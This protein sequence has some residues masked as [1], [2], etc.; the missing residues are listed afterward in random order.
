MKNIQLN[1]IW[2]CLFLVVLFS[3]SLIAQ[4]IETEEAKEVVSSGIGAIVGGDVAHAR[5][6]AVEDA[7]R[8]ALEQ[9]MGMMIESETLV[10]NYQV[11]ED[12]IFSKT[13]GYIQN[14]EVIQEKKRDEMLYEVT[15]KAAVKVSN[16]QDDL[17]GITTLMRRKNMPRMMMMIEE[18]NIGETPSYYTFSADMNAAESAIM[19][20]F[21]AKGFR[22]IDRNTIQRSLDQQKAA[23]I[24]AGNTAEAASLG[25]AV[26]AEVILTG[27][28]LAKSTVVEVYGTT[29]KSQQAT[30]SV[31]AIRTDTGDIIATNTAQGAY[32][33][34]DDIIG[35][36]KAIQKACASL[37]D[38][39]MDQIL[40]RWQ[41][42]V[43]S[44]GV[45]VLKVQGISGFSQLSKFK[46][47]LKYYVRGLVDVTQREWNGAFATLELNMKGNAD[48]LAAR[49]DG[50]D[51]EGI[52]VSVIGMSQN[53]V[54]VQLSGAATE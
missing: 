16:L 2:L 52:L 5:D 31:R 21:M 14:Y 22:F 48:D 8:K 29:Q 44:G 27:K 36:T 18:Q 38:E 35:G 33:H 50:K 19:E 28:A 47:A 1:A 6:D 32:P 20:A 37:S 53:S 4:D 12:N 25:R 11:L 13:Q 54:T 10:E 51:V 46:G 15:V 3:F 23:A 26:G 34:I 43:S 30:V 40:E 39:I 41:T 49:L 17:A 9:V 45:I 24:L 7:L 42:D